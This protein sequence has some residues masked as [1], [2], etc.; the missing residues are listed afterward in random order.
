MK[1]WETALKTFLKKY[2]NNPSFEGALLCGSYAWGN[3]NSFSD[4]DV[5]ILTSN[6]QDWRERGNI[7]ID[8]Y[9]VE[10]FINPTKQI[11][12]KFRDETKKGIV[13]CATMF[14]Y[15]KI[16]ADKNGYVK[17]LQKEAKT[18]LK[19]TMPKYKATDLALD[20]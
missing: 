15:G 10:Y 19:K 6:S 18:V 14:A 5:N 20:F 3:Q 9:L 7:K 16:I 2:E 11:H 4:I 13:T 1:N 17:K 8:D 12:Q